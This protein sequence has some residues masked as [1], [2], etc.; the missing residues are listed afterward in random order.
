MNDTIIL[1]FQPE[2]FANFIHLCTCGD[3]LNLIP[4]TVGV[5]LPAQQDS[6]VV[7]PSPNRL[8]IKVCMYMVSAGIKEKYNG[9]QY[10]NKTP[11]QTPHR[12]KGK[13][14]KLT[15]RVSY[16]Y[17]IHSARTLLQTNAHLQ[18]IKSSLS[19]GICL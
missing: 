4:R 17:Y 12:Q 15:A 2:P 5:S 9:F 19:S 3:S 8:S 6:M 13:K 14:D 16:T 11:P 1:F 10:N 18:I 7:P